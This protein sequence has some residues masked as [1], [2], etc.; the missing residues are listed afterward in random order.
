MLQIGAI[1]RERSNPSQ[2]RCC[3]YLEIFI[4]E[5]IGRKN[6][7]GL[8]ATESRKIGDVFRRLFRSKRS[9]SHAAENFVPGYSKNMDSVLACPSFRQ[10]R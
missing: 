8:L 10:E 3:A 4:A 1:T 6:V 7:P 2:P 9:K 5:A